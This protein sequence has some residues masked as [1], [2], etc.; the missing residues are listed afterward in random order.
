LR[1]TFGASG[2]R[3]E[4]HANTLYPYIA[5]QKRFAGIN[6][7]CSVL[8]PMTQRMRLFTPVTTHPCHMRRPIK[9]VEAMVRIQER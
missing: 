7:N 5:I 9:T 3:V 8:R 4:R 1:E 2:F 6:P